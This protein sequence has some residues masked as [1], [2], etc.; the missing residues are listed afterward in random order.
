M[1]V[2][3]A[4][5]ATLAG[6]GADHVFGVVGSG[7][8]HVTNALVRHGVRFVATRHEG[9]A[10][11]A[12]DAYARV[13]GRAALVTVHQGCGLTNAMTGVAEAAKSRTPMVVLAAEPAA[14]AL[15]SNF[16]VDQ[17]ALARA[18]GAVSERVHGADTAV[19]D[20]VRAWRRAVD[21][22]RTVLLN[23]PLDV[24]AQEAEVVAPPGAPPVHQARAADEAVAALADL[25]ARA[26]RPVFIAGR[27]ALDAGPELTS[28]AAACGA[29]LATSAVA[30][31]LFAGDVWSL[32]VAGGFATPLAAELIAAAD[33][34]VAWGASLNMW[35]TRHGALVGGGATVVQVDLDPAALG[36]HHRIDLG[37][38]G[39]VRAGARAVLAALPTAAPGHRAGDLGDSTRAVPRGGRA[40]G[41]GTVSAGAAV[42]YRTEGVRVRISAAGRWRDVPYEDDSDAG[43]ID[44]RTVTIALDDLLPRERVVAVD[45][46][47]FMG[48]PAMFLSV[49]DRR[50]FCF[51]QAFQ[52]IGLGLASALGAALAAPGRL[53]VAA[54]GDGGFLMSIAELETVCRLGIGMLIVVYND[55]A[56]GAEVHHFGPDGHP[57]E[58]VVFPET[59]LAAIARGYGCAAVTVRRPDDLAPV[60]GWAAG[61]RDVPMVVDVKVTSGRPSWWLEEAF[62]GH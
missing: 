37:I 30:K 35:T 24:Q 54:C 13:S 7:N 56:Y 60:A 38:T 48:Y 46:G 6:L 14:A 16:R 62:R 50:G 20:T 4:V 17:D 27:G 9:G 28:L 2:A 34:V 55:H 19:A 47:N 23:L 57:L 59:D 22:R 18:V 12:A 49:P 11:T 41:E 1:I 36:A 51:T 8:F 43:R 31:G 25:L 5:G 33:V 32:D 3:E 40:E 39:D 58:T 29:L 44:P 52:S 15:R 42:G 26:E 61:P 53:P 10:A 21:D 45:S